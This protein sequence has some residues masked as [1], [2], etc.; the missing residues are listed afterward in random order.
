[1]TSS[2]RMMR[3]M[4]ART[5]LVAIITCLTVF[6]LAGVAPA[7]TQR[8]R[9]GGDDKWRPAHSYIAKGDAVVWTNPDTKVHDVYRYKGP[10]EDG[11]LVRR[12]EPGDRFRKTFKEAGNYLFRCARHSSMVEGQCK[13]MCGIVH[14]V[15]D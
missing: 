5:L 9:A 11:Y 12:L 13:G 3:K 14:V 7:A 10:W 15:Q 6:A 2:K 4:A 1:M 8:V